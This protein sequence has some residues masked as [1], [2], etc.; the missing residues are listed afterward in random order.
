MIKEPISMEE[1]VYFTNRRIKDK[2]VKV[3]AYKGKC[4]KCGKGLMGKER[5]EKTGKPKIRSAVYECP[6]CGHKVEKEEYE[7]T[8][9]G[10]SK[11]EC[12][13]CGYAGEGEFPFMRK[14]V[15]LF[16]EETQKKR[17]A[18]AIVFNCSKCK[19]KIIVTKKM[20]E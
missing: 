4:P 12:P 17:S 19:A 5:D 10:Q 15:M 18:D 1:L 13:E 11:Y 16:D 6:E 3:W 14:K 9:V 8:L 20:K 7:D 2:I